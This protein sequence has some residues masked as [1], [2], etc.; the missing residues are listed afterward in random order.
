[1]KLI[2][3]KRNYIAEMV[4]FCVSCNDI[5]DIADSYADIEG[6]AYKDYYCQKCYDKAEGR[7]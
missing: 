1:M 6:K 7:E 5:I 2:K 4:V 3:A